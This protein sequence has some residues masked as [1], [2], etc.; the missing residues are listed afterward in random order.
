MGVR[1][2]TSSKV[3]VGAPPTRW[4]GESG[5]AQLRMRGLDVLEL[6]E[7]RVLVGVADLRRVQLVVEPVGALDQVAQLGD[8]CGRE[9]DRSRHEDIG[10]AAA[11]GGWP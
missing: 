4:V 10:G 5:V 2:G 1:W 3:A 8:A 7:Q 6:A 9:R 11:G